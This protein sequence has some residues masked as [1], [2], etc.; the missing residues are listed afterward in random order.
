VEAL[1]EID[2]TS[3]ARYGVIARKDWIFKQL[4]HYIKVQ[5]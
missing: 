2:A 4:Q 5:P 3:D 1:P